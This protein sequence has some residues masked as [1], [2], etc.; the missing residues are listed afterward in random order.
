MQE[1]L[2]NL[3]TATGA[4]VDLIDAITALHNTIMEIDATNAL[5][6]RHLLTAEYLLLTQTKKDIHSLCNEIDLLLME[7]TETH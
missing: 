1:Q 3:L 4:I 2:T 7:Q 6:L 5:N